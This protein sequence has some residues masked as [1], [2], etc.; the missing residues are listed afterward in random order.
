MLEDFTYKHRGNYL[1]TKKVYFLLSI[2]LLLPLQLKAQNISV[3]SFK[4]VPEDMT[5]RVTAPVEDQNGE[6]CALIK[7]RTTQ[8]DFVFEGD[9]LGIVK[10]I[11]KTGEIW[12]YVPSKAKKLSVMH[13]KLGVLDNYIY[14]EV[15]KAANVYVM[16]LTTAKV[17][18][19]VEDLEIP[20]QW[21]TIAS[22]PNGADVYINNQFV[23]V[24][25]YQAKMKIGSYNYR[26]E[27]SMYHSEVGK[28]NLTKEA[29]TDL[30][31]NLQPN[32]G[33]V[34]I[35]TT[36]EQGASVEIDGKASN[37]TTPF[38]SQQ[39]LSGE[40]SLKVKKVMF[41]PKILDFTVVDGKTI[42]LSVNLEPNF[43]EVKISTEPTADIYIDD[44]KKGNGNYR[45][46]LNPGLH[47]FEARKEKYTSDK[48]Q[49]EFIA[50]QKARINLNPMAKT[51]SV[52][53]VTTP[54]NA[55]I[56]LNGKNYGTTPITVKD[57]LIGDY[58]ITL[59]KESYG[60]V[61]K[62][63]TIT[64]NKTLSISE[65]LPAEMPVTISSNPASVEL[66]IDGIS[67]GT[68]PQTL[69]LSFGD[70][71]IK[72]V[73]GA[74]KTEE[75]IRVSQT[76]KTSWIFD[77]LHFTDSRD[78]KSYRIVKIE[79]H[80]WMAENLN[81]ATS[82]GSWCY[83]NNPASGEKYGRLYNYETAKNVCPSG[84]HLATDSEWDELID[85]LGGDE[86]AGGK[87]KEGGIT[88]WVSPNTGATNES[89]FTALPGGYRGS[90]GSFE[91]EFYNAYFWSS[92]AFNSYYLW[93]RILFYNDE[94]VFRDLD[95][96]DYGFSVRC[97]RD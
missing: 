61:T 41:K 20:M 25:P 74:E 92:T 75:T 54:F 60:T 35:N 24:A 21:I 86:L 82:K 31:A 45:G 55:G 89:G 91:G 67:Y 81:Y 72:L 79:Q 4:S 85:Y 59:E 69:I 62:S 26:I 50:G 34:K 33:Y 52:D 49:E 71:S 78:G 19:L 94:S 27:K 57:L 15:I 8:K 1:V 40:H 3:K 53:I 48:I 28:F 36:P 63:I 7:V 47:A 18:T 70:H 23:G 43:A 14:P 65:T 6:K 90:G 30:S 56:K 58:T 64:E 11:Q 16:E 51:G 17:I 22:N 2:I 76:G 39:L 97:V 37:R 93:Y 68:T 73:N 42:P 46:R 83:D 13:S 9:M 29:R 32:F 77:L 66:I 84:W 5:G 87:L 12:L 95:N 96:K 88:H 10:T 44:V 38:T 80:V